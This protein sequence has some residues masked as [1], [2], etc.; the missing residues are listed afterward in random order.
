MDK[1]MA[2]LLSWSNV[3]EKVVIKHLRH[4]NI[5]ISTEECITGNESG[6]LLRRIT[7]P[8]PTKELWGLKGISKLVPNN[9]QPSTIT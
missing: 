1:S 2:R 6:I 8:K 9:A 5:G 7:T 4:W 3:K